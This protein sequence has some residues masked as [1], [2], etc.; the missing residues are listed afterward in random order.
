[1]RCGAQAWL[2]VGDPSA[3]ARTGD[4]RLDPIVDAKHHPN[5]IKRLTDGEEKPPPRLGPRHYGIKPPGR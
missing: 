4:Y 3:E 1:L 5:A 2:C